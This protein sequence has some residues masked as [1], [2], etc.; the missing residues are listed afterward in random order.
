MP[1]Y[2]PYR[3]QWSTLDHKYI[4]FY[5]DQPLVPAIEPGGPHWAGWL[6]E[7]SSFAFQSRAGADC[8]VRK[9]TAQRGGSYWYAYRRQEQHMLKRYLARGIDLTVAR[10]ETVAAVLN[11]RET[12]PALALHPAE[13]AQS[14]QAVDK[15]TIAP[16]RKASSASP[17]LL[18]SKLHI[19]RLPMQYVPRARLL[20]QLEQG[21]EGALT[22]VS[23]PAGSGKTTLLAA[24]AS[25]THFPVAWISLETADNDPA[26][27]LSYLIAA[28]ARLDERFET[29]M[30]AY[31][32][33]D[34]RDAERVLT[35]ILNDLAQLLQQDVFVILDD[36]HVLTTEAIHTLLR[37]LLDH[38]PEH[39]HL[40]I[41][42][43]AD[44][45]VSLARLRARGQLNEVRTT[46]LRFASGEVASLV[47]TMGLALSDEATDL[48][49]QRTEGWIAGI[50]LLALA[51]RGQAD[52]T[53]FLQTFR[54]THRFLLDYVSEEVLAQQTPETRRFLLLSCVLERMTGPLCDAVTELPD[55][56]SRLAQL[57]RANL[58]VSALDNTETWYRYHPLFANSLRTQLQKLEPD[59][60]PHLYARASQWYEQQQSLEEACD[61]A[62][63]AGE[64]ARAANLVTQLLPSLVEQGRFERLGNWLSQLPVELIVTSPQLYITLPWHSLS[65]RPLESIARQ[66]QH[67]EQHVQEQQTT[68]SAWEEAQGV[69]SLFQALNALSEHRHKQAFKLIHEA[70]QHLTPRASEL[71][72][73]LVR[74]LQLILSLTYSERGDLSAA[75]R[76]LRDLSMEQPARQRSL[77]QMAAMFLLGELYKAQGQLHKAEK[78]YK[79]LLLAPG[80]RQDLAPMLLLLQSFALMRQACLL[81]ERNRLEGAT[82]GIE[83]VLKSLPGA[84]LKLIP[85]E[86]HQPFY[87]YGLWIQARIE[88]AQ[89]R[90]EA[91]RYFLE[92]ARQHPEIYEEIHPGKDSSPVDISTLVARL[93]L[94]CGEFEMANRWVETNSIRYDDTPETLAQGQQVFAYLT[95]ARILIARGRSRQAE[96]ETALKQANILLERW[97]TCATRLGFQGWL[98]ELQMLTALAL[99]AQ[100]KT[101]QAL[102]TLGGV[103]AQAEPEGYIRLFADEG[104]PMRHILSQVSMYTTASARYIQQI[105]TAMPAMSLALPAPAAQEVTQALIDPLSSRERDVLSLLATGAS[106]QQIAERLVISLNTA[107]RHV[108]HILAKLAVLNR[109]QAAARARELGLL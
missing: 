41:G 42:T 70:L 86:L 76:I 37:F 109:T 92:A 91:A 11:G 28:L 58:F 90:A 21:R 49:E 18:T 59:L 26:R 15:A 51:L 23:A 75:E 93:A 1:R 98:I 33:S 29:A 104:E 40:V 54:G 102:T 77:I 8:T 30:Q 31:H 107:K 73:M 19:P 88:L 47:H 38:L 17:L 99:Q 100:G 105:L 44:P 66:L 62:F 34:N 56:Q 3:L 7:I 22:L 20:A 55:S 74:F 84:M 9:E 16:P 64:L 68:D 12:D 67:M 4:V 101:R 95:L 10:L 81:Y 48:L 94:S 78:L 57:L 43:R 80:S 45:P 103:L 61:Y 27:F 72:Q 25:S 46:E 2:I 53:T 79:T 106:N 87:G 50:Q 60:L 52:A 71:S 6:E 24:W 35:G 65:M 63:L 13:E 36:Y 83:Q 5:E 108:K 69:L 97:H 39:L 96:A 82:Y 32:I 85:P 14:E 89:G